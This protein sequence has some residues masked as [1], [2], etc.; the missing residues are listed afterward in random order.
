MA[1]IN[2]QANEMWAQ[3]FDGSHSSS[4][5][6]QVP[7][8]DAFVEIALFSYWAAG[9]SHHESAAFIT[10]I[11]SASGVENFPSANVTGG[12]LVSVA[13]RRAVT[14]VTFKVEVFQTKGMARWMIYHWG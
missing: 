7:N 2:M 5:T 8:Q 1:V 6:V 12:D 10:Q 13:F 14:S 4:R 3:N 9:E 11:V